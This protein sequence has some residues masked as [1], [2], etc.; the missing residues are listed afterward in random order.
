MKSD[1]SSAVTKAVTKVVKF[2]CENMQIL[3]SI[4]EIIGYNV[5]QSKQKVLNRFLL[6]DLPFY[7]VLIYLVCTIGIRDY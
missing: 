6:F 1:R 7:A 4:C 3:G 2:Y 5:S